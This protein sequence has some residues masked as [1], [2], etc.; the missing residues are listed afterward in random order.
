MPSAPL[1]KKLRDTLEFVK[2]SHTVFAL[3][4]ALVAM[5]VAA[6][7]LPPL[8]VVLLILACMATART[9]AM[10]FNRLADW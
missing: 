6:G 8:R 7:G 9:A 2:F 1:W 10:A 5:G 3:P 4:F